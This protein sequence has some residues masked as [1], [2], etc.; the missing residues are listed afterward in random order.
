MGLGKKSQKPCH[1]PRMSCG[2]KSVGVGRRAELGWAYFE[3]NQLEKK[4]E[5]AVGV[6]VVV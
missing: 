6:G 5:S 1:R 2:G 3:Q 4:T